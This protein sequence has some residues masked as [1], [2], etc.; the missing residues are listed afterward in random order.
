MSAKL[1]VTLISVGQI[2]DGHIQAGIS[3]YRR[4][5]NCYGQIE[6]IV[7]ADEPCPEKLS[8]KQKEK[9]KEKEGKRIQEKIPSGAYVISLAIE[10]KPATEQKFMQKLAHLK[11]EN[12]KVC[13]IIGG[14]LGLWE[15]I[16]KNSHE[17]ISFSGLTI[18]HGLT[19]LLWMEKMAEI[20]KQIP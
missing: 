1:S 8:E 6:E 13:F 15:E 12:V 10:G 5:A 11:E 2:R 14:S 20:L 17:R 3:F 18:P 7:L 4:K 16:K 19:K 9:V